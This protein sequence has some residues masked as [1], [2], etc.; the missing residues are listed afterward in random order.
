MKK[1]NVLWKAAGG[2]KSAEVIQDVLGNMLSRPGETRWSS[3]FDAFQ[4]IVNIKEK[5][6][7]LHRAF[8]IYKNTI[9]ENEFDYIQEY[10]MRTLPVAEALDIMQ[11]ETKTIL[12]DSSAVATCA[13][14]KNAKN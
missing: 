12:W 11:S 3:L 8:N 7:L 2:P 5:S 13:K 6:L 9:N 1:C 4:K 14:K 10:L